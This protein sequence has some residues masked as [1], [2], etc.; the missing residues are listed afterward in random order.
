MIH[1][2]KLQDGKEVIY[3]ESF[4]TGKKTITIDGKVLT[5]LNRKQFVYEDQTYTIKGSFLTG[6]K[7]VGT[8][9][10]E[11]LPKLQKWEYILSCLP[12]IMI[13]IGGMIGALFGCI[14]SVSTI[15]VMRSKTHPVL[16]VLV[17]L[18]FAVLAFL[19]WFVVVN[20]LF[21]LIQ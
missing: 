4:W 14:F 21:L 19:A 13:F 7:L 5:R 11:V 18:L 1:N 17:S 2:T 15:T 20:Y 6:A 3:E 16:K 12:L 8:T 10:I 9:E